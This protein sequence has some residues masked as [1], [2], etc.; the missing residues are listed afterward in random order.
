MIKYK[1]IETKNKKYYILKYFLYFFPYRDEPC[2]WFGDHH[3]AER[4]WD[5]PVRVSSKEYNS[6][7]DVEKRICAIEKCTTKDKNI[8][9]KIL[10]S[11]EKIDSHKLSLFMDTLYL[12][13]LDLILGTPSFKNK[14]L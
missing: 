11:E 4:G 2:L 7:E 5:H 12:M 10:F 6:F 1:I 14:K 9:L 13:N 3:P 8:Y